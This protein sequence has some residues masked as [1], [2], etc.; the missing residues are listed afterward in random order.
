[1]SN[2]TPNWLGEVLADQFC[3]V[4]GNGTK[5]TKQEWFDMM[6]KKDII[7]HTENTGFLQIVPKGNTAK[8]VGQTLLEVTSTAHPRSPF[9]LQQTLKAEK[10][11][12][13]W[14]FTESIC[15][16][17]NWIIYNYNYC[18]FSF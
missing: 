13:K 17:L 9:N 16:I 2:A 8:V 5:Q 10:I 18:Y 6:N 1:M 3:L 7:Y 12:G 14:Q 15:D 11:D 4:H